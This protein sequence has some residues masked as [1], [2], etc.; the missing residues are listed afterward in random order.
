MRLLKTTLILSSL[1]TGQAFAAPGAGPELI[2]GGGRILTMEGPKPSYVEAVAVDK[3]R[4]VFAGSRAAAMKL[5]G[6]RTK[7]KNLGGQLMMPGFIDGDTHILALFLLASCVEVAQ[8]PRPAETR[9][10]NPASVNC[11]KKGGALSIV[12]RSDGD[13]A[14]IGTFPSGKRCEEGALFRN[15]CRPG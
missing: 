6:T 4:I 15:E 9:M 13:E 3:G 10:V 8:A 14:G 1:L 5:S 12:R 2:I 11:T 7:F